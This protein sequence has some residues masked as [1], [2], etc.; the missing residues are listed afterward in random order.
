MTR[1]KLGKNA[2]D[3]IREVEKKFRKLNLKPVKNKK[4]KKK[5]ENN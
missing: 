4:K 1:I 5:N 3:I 2:D